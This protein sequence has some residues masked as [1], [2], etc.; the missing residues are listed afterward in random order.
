[1]T[2]HHF[3][4]LFLIAIATGCDN[5]QVPIISPPPQIPTSNPPNVVLSSTAPPV[6]VAP[7]SVT[8]LVISLSQD[9]AAH[10]KAH[11]N[12]IVDL[13]KKAEKRDFLV[14]RERHAAWMIRNT[15]GD[16]QSLTYDVRKTDSL[17][18]PFV[19]TAK[20][21]FI[22]RDASKDPDGSRQ[23]TIVICEFESPAQEGKWI[24][25]D[26]TY[27][28]IIGSEGDTKN[29]PFE[30]DLHFIAQQYNEHFSELWIYS[31]PSK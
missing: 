8:P 20:I 11:I 27:K 12:R 22:H 2:R 30:S 21:T 9:P 25:R 6:I 5:K 31:E 19:A 4:A 29:K 10:F 13:I 28:Q 3:T 15:F 16:V 18:S 7:V 26:P 17:V 24:F 1:M 14:T 23:F